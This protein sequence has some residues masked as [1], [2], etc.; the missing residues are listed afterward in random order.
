M[1]NGTLFYGDN[2]DVLRGHIADASVDLVYLDPPFNSNQNYNVLFAEQDGTRAGAQI[3]AFHDTWRWDESSALAFQELIEGGPERAAGIMAAFR[4]FLGESDMITYLAMMAPRLVELHRVLKP[5]GSLYLH[6]DPTASHYLKLLLDAVFGPE[7]FRSEIIWER[8]TNTG[9]SKASAR[10]FSTD[11]DTILFYTR[12]SRDYTFETQ[13][14]PYS[15]QYI[16]RYYIYDD[17]DGRGRY[18]VQALKTVS[19]ER[20][21]RLRVE[22]RIVQ[23]SGRYLRFKD[24]LKDKKGVPVNDLWTDIEPV[25]PIAKEKLGYP[26]QKPEALLERIINASSNPGDVVLDPFCGCGTAVV[27]AQKLGRRW[28]GIDVTHLTINLVKYRLHDSFGDQVEYEVIGEPTDLSGAEALA[29]QDRYQF[30]YWALG[31]VD[32]RPVEEKK[33]ADRGIDGRLRFI[34]DPYKPPKQII[35][36]VKSNNVGVKDVRELGNVVDREKAQIGVLI[37]LNEPTGPMRKEAAGMGFYSSP[38]GKHAKLQILTIE[39]LLAG[40]RIDSPRTSGANVTFKRATRTEKPTV[41]TLSL[42]PN[43]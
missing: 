35:L 29:A 42:L 30:Q 14:R 23:G 41:E 18:Q 24:Y 3:K 25:N 12:E 26:T 43:E 1:S 33:S 39:Q 19:A 11:H 28:I 20:L 8:T 37:T 17:E 31:L 6:C 5:T 22:N 13:Y 4:A 21:E 15:K 27:A 16:K 38:W 10:R 2:L 9:S 7:S 36:S 40:A 34:D 32:A